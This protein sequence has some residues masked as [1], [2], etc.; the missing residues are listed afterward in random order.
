MP[1]LCF[2]VSAL[3][4][5]FGVIGGLIFYMGCDDRIKP[6]NDKV[7]LLTN[8]TITKIEYTSYDCTYSNSICL[9]QGSS[10]YNRTS[11]VN[12]E[13]CP[14]GL[15]RRRCVEYL[16]KNCYASN[17][18]FTYNISLN[19][20]VTP[21]NQKCNIVIYDL[22]KNST[23]YDNITSQ[24]IYVSDGCSLTKREYDGQDRD[25]M[26]GLIIMIL[27]PCVYAIIFIL[28]CILAMCDSATKITNIENPMGLN[29]NNRSQR[30]LRSFYV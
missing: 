4:V 7:D 20:N 2:I 23:I 16:R 8:S 29:K 18:T 17:I 25:A 21:T 14:V 9:E 28:V 26:A 27:W 22:E 19:K 6:C 1:G 10:C 11:I 13:N 12:I 24:Q 3:P 30:S 15:R 5:L